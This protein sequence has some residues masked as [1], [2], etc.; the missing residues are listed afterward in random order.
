MD[1]ALNVTLPAELGAQL[2]MSGPAVGSRA[3]TIGTAGF[4]FEKLKPFLSERLLGRPNRSRPF[5]LDP[6][7]DTRNWM[8]RSRRRLRHWMRENPY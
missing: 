7:L 1:D 3:M 2:S 4:D 6:D 5:P 8:E